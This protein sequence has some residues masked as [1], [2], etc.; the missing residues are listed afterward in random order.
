MAIGGG[1]GSMAMTVMP[2]GGQF[3]R[4]ALAPITAVLAQA[5]YQVL[6]RR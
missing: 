4:Q 5:P 1:F 2:D 6:V 3:R